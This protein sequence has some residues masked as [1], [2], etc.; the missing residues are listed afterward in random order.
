MAQSLEKQQAASDDSALWP[1]LDG[2]EGGRGYHGCG[3]R[4]LK[5]LLV[6]SLAVWVAQGLKRAA[7]G[8]STNDSEGMY[9]GV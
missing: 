4:L 3:E 6:L 7:E 5:F 8:S 9:P 1:L 2:V